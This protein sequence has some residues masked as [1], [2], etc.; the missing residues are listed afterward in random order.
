M[1]AVGILEP[2]HLH[3]AG[4]VDVAF[5]THVGAVR[6][7][8][9]GHALG[10]QGGDDR[11]DLAADPPDRRIGLVGSGEFGTVDDERG[12]AGA[13]GRKTIFVQPHYP[14]SRLAHLAPDAVVA[15]GAVS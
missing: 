12:V 5:E 11:V 15:S 3:F 7:M 1:F 14:G 4:D 13:E 6:V 9:E 2:D 10:F 8:L